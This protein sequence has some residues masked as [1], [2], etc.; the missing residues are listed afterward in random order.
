MNRDIPK[1]AVI[2]RVNKGKSSIVST[3]AEDESVKIDPMP[4]TTTECD[5]YPL[6]VDDQPLLVFIDTP[7]FQQAPRMLSWLRKREKS[8]ATRQ[9]VIRQFYEKYNNRKDFV[10]ECKLLKP[11]LKGAGI[12]YVVDGAK[13]FRE[14]YEAEMEI[15]RWTGQPRIALLNRIGENDYLREWKP[16]LDQYFNVVREFSAHHVHFTDRIKLLMS[17]REINEQWRENIDKAIYYLEKERHRRQKKSAEII[18]HLIVDELTYS[19]EI[20]IK[21]DEIIEKYKTK[22]ESQFHDYLRGRERKAHFQLKQLYHHK[23]IQVDKTELEKPVFEQDLF[24]KSTWDKLGLTPKQLLA[25]GAIVG[26]ATG[27]IIDAF[28]GGMSFMTGTVIGGLAGG[29]SVLYFSAKRFTKISDIIHVFQGY[30]IIRIGPHK[31]PNLPWIL[32]DR[33][34]IHFKNIYDLPHSRRENISLHHK[35]IVADFDTARRKQ[36]S[37]LFSSI[38]KRS[39]EIEELQAKLAIIIH[40]L[41]KEI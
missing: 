29:V 14:N 33:A 7:G 23:K 3:L 35:S 19:T 13:P 15:L 4:G 16:A 41:M 9:Q 30:K 21:D 34:L 17:L 39:E 18:A 24:S 26:S 32:L 28:T 2:G 22:L 36:L 12:I 38:R 25:L 5:E 27:G 37:K 40:E 8:A 11:L 20:R 10:D 6:R 31:N 1:L